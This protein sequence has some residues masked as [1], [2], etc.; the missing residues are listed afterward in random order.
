VHAKTNDGC[1]GAGRDGRMRTRMRGCL[2]AHR[3]RCTG[4]RAS[5]RTAGRDTCVGFVGEACIRMFQPAMSLCL[6][7]RIRART[8]PV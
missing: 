2:R 3:R 1:G 5:A 8:H 7:L 4:E 6:N